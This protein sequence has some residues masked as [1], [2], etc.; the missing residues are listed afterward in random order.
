MNVKNYVTKVFFAILSIAMF[1]SCSDEEPTPPQDPIP[2]VMGIS[3]SVDISQDI[4]SAANVYLQYIGEDGKQK[5]E[6][7][8][9]TSIRKNIV[10]KNLSQQLGYRVL[11]KEKPTNNIETEICSV[12]HEDRS[13]IML[14]DTK[15]NVIAEDGVSILSNKSVRK[16]A[17][18][19]WISKKAVLTKAGFKLSDNKKE[20]NIVEIEWMEPDF[21]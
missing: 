9:S 2:D 21:I 17:L 5:I 12:Y 8:S 19:D 18:S 10:T 1:A 14:I 6:T 16:E 11:L 7:V 20:F 3:I 13:I 4:L 15:S